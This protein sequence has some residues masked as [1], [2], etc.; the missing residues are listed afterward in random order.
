MEKEKQ[1]AKTQKVGE[2][3]DSS[4]AVETIGQV[5][6]DG[7]GVDPIYTDPTALGADKNESV[8]IANTG[9]T[10]ITTSQATQGIGEAVDSSKAVETIGQVERDGEGVDPIYSDPTALGADRNEK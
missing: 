8:T 2:M 10:S 9:K 1:V 5:E 3:V 7:E 4:E 6:R